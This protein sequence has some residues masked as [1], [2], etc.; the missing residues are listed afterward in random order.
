MLVAHRPQPRLAVLGL[1]NAETL[2][3][4]VE[5]DQIRDVLVVL[6][7][8]DGARLRSLA[9]QTDIVALHV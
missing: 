6:D 1:D 9:H 2:L 5:L 4:Q 3:A 8:D 7:E